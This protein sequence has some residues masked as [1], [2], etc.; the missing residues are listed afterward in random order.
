MLLC[1][2]TSPSLSALPRQALVRPGE[3][4]G[5]PGGDVQAEAGGP[6]RPAAAGAPP[7]GA[8]HRVHA[9]HLRTG[10]GAAPGQRRPRP[11]GHLQETGGPVAMWGLSRGKTLLKIGTETGFENLPIP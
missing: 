2:S 11:P 5:S 3:P 10:G 4:A 7:G 6:R 9:A 1:K 8:Q